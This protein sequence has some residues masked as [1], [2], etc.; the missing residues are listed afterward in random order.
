M[1][2]LP[3]SMDHSEVWFLCRHL[4]RSPE[5]PV[6]APLRS[7]LHPSHLTSLPYG[8]PGLWLTSP[9][10]CQHLIQPQ[11]LLS[12]RLQSC[13]GPIPL[14]GFFHTCFCHGLCFVS[15]INSYHGHCLLLNELFYLFLFFFLIWVEAWLEGTEGTSNTL[16]KVSSNSD[17][18][19]HF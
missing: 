5:H 6:S 4:Q 14:H 2:P 13:D 11:A 7:A 19:K 1:Q 9:T 10:Q 8:P 16:R 17:L 18:V 3:A 15:R 12:R